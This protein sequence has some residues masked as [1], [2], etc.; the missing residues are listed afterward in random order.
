M[1]LSR[2]LIET[3][4]TYLRQLTL[5]DVDSVLQI[6]SDLEAM[7]YSPAATTQDRA[8]AEGF[9]KWNIENYQKHGLGTWAVISKSTGKYV[10]QSG[11]IPQEIGLEVFYSFIREFW[12]QGLATKVA[13]ACRDHAFQKLREPRLISI[14]HPENSR[15]LKVARKLAMQEIG[16]IEFW[17]RENLLFEIRNDIM[18]L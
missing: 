16:M 11:L 12:G 17:N 8:E 13:S 18:E 6:F 15:A 10:G 2:T 1:T 5:D 3:E 4:R 7:K 14:I 9:I